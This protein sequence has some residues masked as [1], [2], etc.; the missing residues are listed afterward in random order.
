MPIRARAGEQPHHV[1]RER[2]QQGAGERRGEP[3]QHRRAAA[4]MVGD[5]AEADQHRHDDDRIDGEDAGRHRVAQVPFLR[6][7][8]IGHGRRGARP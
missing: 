5:V 8:P 7:Q 3:Y 1:G 6:I 2:E 4:D